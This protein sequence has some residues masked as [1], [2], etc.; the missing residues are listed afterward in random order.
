ME[1]NSDTDFFMSITKNS[2]L[3]AEERRKGVLVFSYYSTLTASQFFSRLS[4]SH[5][6]QP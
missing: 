2:F 5:H 1:L 4:H 3:P 6:H